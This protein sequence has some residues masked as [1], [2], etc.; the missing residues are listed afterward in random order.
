ML[1]DWKVAVFNLY[2]GKLKFSKLIIEFTQVCICSHRFLTF[3]IYWVPQIWLLENTV[4]E[5]IAKIRAMCFTVNI[6]LRFQSPVW[7]L[8]FFLRRCVRE[9]L[10]IQN[11]DTTETVGGIRIHGFTFIY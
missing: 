9:G 6:C 7:V 3:R 8:Y 1:D 2:P 10:G 5:R 11:D 4:F